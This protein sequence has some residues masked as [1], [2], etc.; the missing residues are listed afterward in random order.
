MLQLVTE[1]LIIGKRNVYFGLYFSKQRELPAPICHAEWQDALYIEDDR[2]L[3]C[4]G[5]F[6]FN[7]ESIAS[8]SNTCNFRW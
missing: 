2:F 3:L 4:E 6:T 1:I 7:L 5:C 8:Q